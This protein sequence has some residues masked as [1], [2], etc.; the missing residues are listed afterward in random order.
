MLHRS[1]DQIH[2][3][4]GN[5]SEKV[6]QVPH[7]SRKSAILRKGLEWEDELNKCLFNDNWYIIDILNKNECNSLYKVDGQIIKK[8]QGIERPCEL[9]KH[10]LLLSSGSYARIC[11]KLNSECIQYECLIAGTYS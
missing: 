11:I 1:T 6:D 5:G 10:F 3:I 4:N 8:I 2:T 9:T 7:A